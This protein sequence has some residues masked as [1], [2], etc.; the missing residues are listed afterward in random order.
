MNVQSNQNN[1]EIVGILRQRGTHKGHSV[2]PPGAASRRS[3]GYVRF[4]W[5]NR[6]L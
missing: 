3:P 1:P 6:P 2:W 5:P 4:S